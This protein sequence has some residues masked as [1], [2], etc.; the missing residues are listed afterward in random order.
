MQQP[1]PLGNLVVLERD[2][3]DEF[4]F[5]TESTAIDDELTTALT[6]PEGR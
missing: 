2:D 4:L 6:G 3:A 1:F 5:D